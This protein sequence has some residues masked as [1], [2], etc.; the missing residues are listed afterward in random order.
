MTTLKN[1]IEDSG[2]RIEDRIAISASVFPRSSLLAPRSYESGFSLISGIF[3][4]VVIAA[5]GTFAVTLS[6]TQNQSQA[7]DV[8]GSRA[9][10][11]ARAGIEWAAFN[12]ASS[13][14]SAPAAWNGCTQGATPLVTLGGNLSTFTVTV[15]CSATSA[16]DGTLIWI[17]DVSAVAKTTGSIP[18]N[19]NY[20]ERQV[21][22][23]MG[24]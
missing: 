17:Y 23:K 6:T 24:R 7:Q 21:N 12:V 4:L 5:L 11:A 8:L 18:G 1:R 10:Q 15:N 2:S 20:T 13:P 19:P 3:L 14:A 16:V 22:V 9:Y